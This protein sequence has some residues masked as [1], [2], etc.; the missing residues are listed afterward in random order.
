MPGNIS[1]YEKERMSALMKPAI[2]YQG[3]CRPEKS[4]IFP[5]YRGEAD[6]LT[7]KGQNDLF[8]CKK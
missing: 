3:G 5:N 6:S 2:T 8:L 4:A 7:A 1:Y